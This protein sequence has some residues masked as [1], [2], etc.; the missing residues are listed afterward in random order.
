MHHFQA[1]WNIFKWQNFH[2]I[3]SDHNA[4]DGNYKNKTNKFLMFINWMFLS[5]PWIIKAKKKK[6][7][8]EKK[9]GPKRKNSA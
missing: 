9:Y 2:N 8:R 3:I 6:K 1:N 5:N 7:E 4:I